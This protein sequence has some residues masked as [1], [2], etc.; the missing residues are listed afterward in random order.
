M[1]AQMPPHMKDSILHSELKSDDLLIMAS[2]LNPE[3]LLEGN[4]VQLCNNC[5]TEEELNQSFSKLS[6]GGVQ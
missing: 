2:D 6:E 1:A 3:K 5:N 4:T